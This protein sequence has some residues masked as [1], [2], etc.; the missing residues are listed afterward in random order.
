MNVVSL[1]LR[2]RITPVGKLMVDAFLLISCLTLPSSFS[3]SSADGCSWDGVIELSISLP[4]ATELPINFS[5]SASLE[6]LIC[7]KNENMFR[8]NH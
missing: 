2:V 6:K 8:R 7:N 5:S 4:L 3:T 1:P